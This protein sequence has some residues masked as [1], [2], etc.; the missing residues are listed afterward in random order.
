VVGWPAVHACIQQQVGHA[1]DKLSCSCTS[2][3]PM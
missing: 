1:Q 3:S 2:F